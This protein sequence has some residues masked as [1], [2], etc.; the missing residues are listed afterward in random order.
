MPALNPDLSPMLNAVMNDAILP[1][2]DIENTVYNG[3]PVAKLLT[4]V[5]PEGE[6]DALTEMIE[7]GQEL[8]KVIRVPIVSKSLE[9]TVFGRASG[10]D[11]QFDDSD[12]LAYAEYA[13]GKYE[14]NPVIK[15]DDI[16][17]SQNNEAK[18]SMMAL[19]LREYKKGFME[20]IAQSVLA[21][22][23]GD[24]QLIPA[25]LARQTNRQDQNMRAINSLPYLISILSCGN[26]VPSSLT[27]DANLDFSYIWKAILDTDPDLTFES[28]STLVSNASEADRGPKFFF[29][30]TRAYNEL[31]RQAIAFQG[32]TAPMA[33]KDLRIAQFRSMEI[34]GATFIEDKHV[35]LD[36][37]TSPG[38]AIADIWGVDLEALAFKFLPDTNKG[39]IMLPWERMERTWNYSM[40]CV[41]D[42]QIIAQ[43][44]RR[45]LTKATKTFAVA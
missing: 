27:I 31:Y 42:G 12:I 22:R 3:S 36:L 45:F 24:P 23:N 15:W 37:V 10:G 29:L 11:R 44:T 5:R 39:F 2:L 21:A 19:K 17:Y 30:H 9:Q 14:Q 16:R 38:N 41:W 7:M 8:G 25:S 18:V 1:L 13:W 4:G 43:G 35:A 28:A 32:G 34:N 40:G 26:L 33:S 20:F 6:R